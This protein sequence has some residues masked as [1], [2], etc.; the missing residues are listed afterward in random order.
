[1]TTKNL[2]SAF[3]F[4]SGVAPA[5]LDLIARKGEVLTFEAGAVV[6]H[7]NDPAEHFYGL[8]EGEIALSL[9]SNDKVLK[10]KIK[11]EDAVQT[12]MVEEEKWI[13]LDTVDPGQIFGW[14]SLAG[15]ARRTVTAQCTEPCR[16]IALAAVD[17]KA[18]FE[19]DYALGYTIMKKLSDIIAKRLKHRTE[20]LIE[21]WVEAFDTDT[22]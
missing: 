1:M 4:F 5:T 7:L 22:I 6:F 16:V 19:K 9:V 21:T 12:S 18:M 20:K 8:L 3:T 10:T 15:S 14:S 11:Y 2:L 13:V 17:L